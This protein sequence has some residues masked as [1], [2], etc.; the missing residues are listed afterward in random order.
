M[1]S[2]DVIII[3]GGAAGLT[4]AAGMAQLGLKTALI[5]KDH[6]GG[7]CLYF[8]CVPSKSLIKTARVRQLAK[9]SGMYGLPQPNLENSPVSAAEVMNHVHQVIKG[10]EPHDSPERFRSLGCDVYL[11]GAHFISEHEIL[12]DDGDKLSAPKIIISTGSSPRIPDI[13]GLK[14]TEY[15]TNRDIFNID[16]FPK[17]LITLGGG[18]IGV[19][20]S[21]ALS[22]L[23]VKITLIE[24]ASHI[25]SR[26]DE[27]MADVIQSIMREE[28]VTIIT[29]AEILGVKNSAKGKSVQ[30]R[31]N[32]TKKTVTADAL[33]V[34]LGR[35]GNISDLKLENAGVKSERSFI[36]V[37]NKLRTNRKHI[38]ALGDVN[39]NF[40][41]T[42]T[43]G[44]EASFAIKKIALHLPGSFSYN[45]TPWTT[46][47]DPELASVGFNEKRAK[48]MGIPYSVHTSGM[49]EIDRSNAEIETSGKIKVLLDPKGRVIGTQIASVHAGDLITPSLFAV[50]NKWKLTKMLGPVYPYPTFGEIHRKNAGSYAGPKLFNARVRK[51]LRILFHYRGKQ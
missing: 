7:D 16:T 2:H 27:D 50:R 48:E 35:Q 45:N 4:S 5:E 33:L 14:E 34:S 38:F 44:A 18:P 11:Q 47:T 37:D 6:M 3:G 42:H 20:L 36:P 1:S 40:L 23:G 46:Y 51:M 30:Y 19:E 12:L 49:G 13:P 24:K 26:E 31:E 32:G 8:G 10:L 21:Q 39:G 25:L 17:T 15:F 22:R 41:F 43:A 29:N 28:G 9:N